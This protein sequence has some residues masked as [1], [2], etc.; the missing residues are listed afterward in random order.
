MVRA[1]LGEQITA[2]QRVR[3]ALEQNTALPGVRHVRRIEPLNFAAAQRDD[4]VVLHRTRLPV[5][6]V[7]GGDE[8]GDLAAWRHGNGG[9]T[10]EL[11]ERTALV[12]LEMR[13]ADIAKPLD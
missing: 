11:I 4:L 6:D 10:K 3:L 12:R 5:G 7:I 2:K 1:T 9:H 8:C 13:E